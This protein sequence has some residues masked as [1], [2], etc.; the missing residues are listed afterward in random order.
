MSSSSSRSKGVTYKGLNELIAFNKNLS[1]FLTQASNEGLKQQGSS[2]LGSTQRVVP[3][4][5]GRLKRSGGQQAGNLFLSVFYDAHYALFVDVG[6]SRFTGR[7][8]FF[9]VLDQ[10][11]PKIIA[12]INQSVGKMIKSNLGQR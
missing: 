2:L 7:H 8:Y 12:S 4:R 9:R 5:T 1:S 6:T 3:V 11:R 10:Q